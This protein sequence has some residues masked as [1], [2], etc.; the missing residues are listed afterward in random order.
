MTERHHIVFLCIANSARSQMAEGLARATAPPGW[1]V[2][3][4]GTN[5]GRLNPL[6]TEVMAEVGIDISAHRSKRLDEVSVKGADLV[7]TLCS[8][9]ACPTTPPGVKRLNWALPDPAAADGPEEERLEAFRTARSEIQ[10]RLAALWP[11]LDADSR[12]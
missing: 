6:A 3:S 2:S 4:A 10:R 9:E 12:S 8:E 11:S 7:V 5:P 1:T